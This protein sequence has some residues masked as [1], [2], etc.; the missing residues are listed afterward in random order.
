[1]LNENLRKLRKE[2]GMTQSELSKVLGIAQTTYAGYET[3]K[4]E[5][6][7]NTLTKIADYYKISLDFLT[8]RYK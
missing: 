3:G 2:K 7:L 5:P 1:M 6:D 4:S 8:G